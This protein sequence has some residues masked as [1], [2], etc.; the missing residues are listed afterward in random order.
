ME[1]RINREIVKAH[2]LP[3]PKQRVEVGVQQGEVP[4]HRALSIGLCSHG[5]WDQGQALGD[6]IH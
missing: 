3:N 1:R 2:D 6:G 4:E 5:V